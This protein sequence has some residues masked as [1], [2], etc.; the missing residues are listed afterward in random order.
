[1]A[2]RGKSSVVILPHVLREV[3]SQAA[4]FSY[5]GKLGVCQRNRFDKNRSSSLPICHERRFKRPLNEK[6]Y[7][8]LTYGIYGD[9]SLSTVKRTVQPF[10]ESIGKRPPNNEYHLPKS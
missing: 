1:L 5:L 8:A 9:G 4:F 7:D 10:N 3:F 6:L 2:Q